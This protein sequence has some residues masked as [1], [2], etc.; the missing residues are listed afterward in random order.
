MPFRL[1][2][3]PDMEPSRFVGFAGNRIS[4]HSEKRND[5]V[6]AAALA[7]ADARILLTGQGQV[8]VM[9]GEMGSALFSLQD[10][11]ALLPVPDKTIYLGMQ[12]DM[13]IL[14][15][16]SGFDFAALPETIKAFDY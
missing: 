9:A 14:A 7:N 12:D 8:L 6:V 11:T 5:D 10:A 3:A 16:A 2:D 1:F 13:P 15:S 4:R